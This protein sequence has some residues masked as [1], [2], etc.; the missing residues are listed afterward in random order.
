MPRV[1]NTHFPYTKAGEK[2]AAAMKAGMKRAEP[3]LKKAEQKLAE[4]RAF[5]A[6]DVMRFKKRPRAI[7]GY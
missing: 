1:G 5:R 4:V 6:P 3:V 7:Q 2:A